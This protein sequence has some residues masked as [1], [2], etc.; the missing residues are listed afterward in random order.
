MLLALVRWDGHVVI[1]VTPSGIAATLLEGGQTSHSIFKIPINIGRDLMCSI[2]VQNDSA[3]LLR[4]AKLIVWDE[5]PTQHQHYAEAV[6]G[7]LHD[8]M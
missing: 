3:K 8:I 1:R 7:T 4:E 5:A 2:P 6:D